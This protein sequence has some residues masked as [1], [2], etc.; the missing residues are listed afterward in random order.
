[1]MPSTRQ[2]GVLEA[3]TATA[4]GVSR[5]LRRV[6]ITA[7][8]AAVLPAASSA[9]T[10]APD[11][12]PRQVAVRASAQGVPALAPLGAP[13]FRE[14]V[15]D[16]G[17]P[18]LEVAARTGGSVN[19]LSASHPAPG[20]G[21]MYLQPLVVQGSTVR[22]RGRFSL[23]PGL[24]LAGL[25]A[26]RRD[27]T[28]VLAGLVPGAAGI[29]VA[30]SRSN[31]S[32]SGEPKRGSFVVPAGG[33][34][35]LEAEV[36]D[37][38]T[39]RAWRVFAWN[40]GEPRPEVPVAEASE[41]LDGGSAL[42]EAGVWASGSGLR[43]FGELV[44][45][46]GAQPSAAAGAA[47]ASP[48]SV[49]VTPSGAVELEVA[50]TGE[51]V[52]IE[53]D[54]F[55][56][57]ATRGERATASAAF[58]GGRAMGTC[59]GF[60]FRY[61]GQASSYPGS[62][63]FLRLSPIDN[64]CDGLFDEDPSGGGD[65]DG[66]GRTDED[67][68]ESKLDWLSNDSRFGVW[69]T[70]PV[71]ASLGY[72]ILYFPFRV[73]CVFAYASQGNWLLGTVR[74]LP[75]GGGT[76]L[77]GH[78]LA[79]VA[80]DL[81][82][83]ASTPL[84][85]TIL[86]SGAPLA[87]GALFT[88][89]VVLTALTEGGSG[90][91]TV[92]ATVDGQPFALGTSY[93]VEGTH[94]ITVAA[95]DQGG[96][97]ATA[98]RQLG[99]DLSAPVF[100]DIT[101]PDGALTAAAGVALAGRVSADTAQ[102]TVGGTPA[103]LGAA[104][105][106]T[107]P[108]TSQTVPLVEGVTTVALRA[109][110]GVGLVTELDW[111]VERDGTA[112]LVTIGS[113]SSGTIVGAAST[114][115]TGT[116]SDLHLSGVSVNG[117]AATLTGGTWSATVPLLP[118]SNQITA[119]ASDQVGNT[120]SATVTV[121]RDNTSPQITIYESGTPVSGP[122][123]LGR[124][125]VFTAQVTDDTTVQVS[126]SV[127]GATHALGT[128]YGAEGSHQL[129]VSAT[130]EG[131]NT[132]T[133][134]AAF[135]I[136]L[137]APVIEVQSP[138]A[139]SVVAA[140]A[141]TVSGR[142][143]ADTVSVQV[144]G[145]S[146]V[147]DA[148]AGEWRSFSAG[149]VAL[150]SEGTNL[151]AVQAAD[152]VG[153][154]A[155][156]E[157]PLVRDTA[158]PQ[159]T[160]TSP[161]E[162]LVTRFEAQV[163]AGQASD[164]HLQGVTLGGQPLALGAD[165]SFTTTVT[166]AEGPMSLAFVAT[167]T[168]GHATTVT[169]H[170]TLDTIP[171]AITV[172]AD[173]QPLAEGLL[174]NHA[175]APVI[176][177]QDATAVQPTILLNGVPFVS[178]TAVASEGLFL[179]SIQAVDA[180]GNQSSLDRHFRI[181]TS[182]PMLSGIQPADGTVTNQAGQTLTGQCDDAVTVTVNGA[183]AQVVSGSFT[184]AGLMLAEGENT[185]ALTATDAAGNSQTASHR[186]VLDTQPPVLT[187]SEPA[188]GA[189][190]RPSTVHVVG[191]ATDPH[192]EAVALNG[193]PAALSGGAFQAD[194]PLPNEGSNAIQVVARD[195]AGNQATVVR[196]VERDATPP[197]LVVSTPGPG[198]VL[199]SSTVQVSG[200]ATDPHL[201]GVTVNQT[202]V[203]LAGNAFSTDLSLPEGPHTI[204]VEATDTLGLSSRVERSIRVDLTAPTVLI[205]EP[206]AGAFLTSTTVPVRGQAQ[207]AEGIARVTVN[208]REAT[209]QG[210]GAFELADLALPEGESTVTCRAFDTAGNSGVVSR[211]VTVDVQPPAVTSIVPSDGATGVPTSVRPRITFSEPI[212]P[213]SLAGQITLTA[214]GVP[215]Q[216]QVALDAAAT[217]ATVTPV[218]GLQSGVEHHLTVQTGITD[219][220]G[221]VLAAAAQ[222]HFTTTDVTPPPAPQVDPLPSPACVTAAQVSGHAEPG[223]RIEVTGTV[224]PAQI[225]AG[226]DGAFA[227]SVTPTV[228]AGAVSLTVTAV[229]AAGNRSAAVPLLFD[230]DCQ[231]PQVVDATWT[232]PADPGQTVITVRFSEPPAPATLVAG[233]TVQVAGSSGALGFASALAG[234]VLELT[235]AQRPADSELPVTLDL[236]QQVT[237]LAGNALATPFRRLFTD[238]QS[239]TLVAG[240]VF[241]DATSLP[242]AGV[243]V[244][245]VEDGGPVADPHPYV[246]TDGRG[247]FQLPVAGSPVT[248][249]AER[250]GFAPGWRRVVPQP[251][252]S[253]L[254]FD[255]RLTP[256]GEIHH[257]S[258]SAELSTPGFTL[259][260]PAAAVPSEGLDLKLTP[261][262][263]QGLPNLLPP[264]WS[265]DRAVCV[266]ASVSL[267]PPAALT[268]TGSLPPDGVLATF[269]AVTQAWTA[270][271]MSAV[272]NVTASGVWAVVVPDPPPGGPGQA[273]AGFPLPAATQADP[274]E[275]TGQ[276][277][278]DPPTI[279]PTQIATGSLDVTPTYPFASGL[280]VEASLDEA[281]TLV[282]GRT[283][284]QPPAATDLVV[285]RHD[286]SYR[287]VF[288]LGASD[289]ARRLSLSQGVREVR[290]RALPAG[291]R[292]ENL[293]GPAGGTV[294]YPQGVGLV[295]AAGALSGMTS[296]D[297]ADRP[298]DLLPIPLPAG[299]A[300][301]RVV[302]L[303]LGA[304]LL[305]PAE[306]SFPL[307]PEP[308]VQHLVLVPLAIEDVT[309]WRLVGVAVRDG[310]RLECAPTPAP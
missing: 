206:A 211:T 180:A 297:L 39:S 57:F 121:I 55:D 159:L 257:L 116:A 276:L 294:A 238:G 175:I 200:T 293:V 301:E 166:L 51:T 145:Q 69:G 109:V 25:A 91:A 243:R 20:S 227:V 102:V 281:L 127:D 158:G 83:L 268:L 205:D 307:G 92:T 48:P 192:L 219:R 263:E 85:V 61:S 225:T 12:A 28:W 65:Q 62:Q 220:A 234:N 265:V 141:E 261:L 52:R 240:E 75:T 262:S 223:A 213:A 282:D 187:L 79:T 226:A 271:A 174:V 38:G 33:W 128:P 195:R 173:G 106:S 37:A 252:F 165:G 256:L 305:V 133:E 163:A 50:R 146:A 255:L 229:D 153:N 53:P 259:T 73:Y 18:V 31:G 100:S 164:P 34:F 207:D 235:L 149:G 176:E 132:A 125:A 13:V 47:A 64:D 89:P 96:Q 78:G 157:H 60:K 215:I 162:G 212:A 150:P 190:I 222:A 208:G 298:A 70:G 59:D 148:P 306:L 29:D 308:D 304:A 253:T 58:G 87:D 19:P 310:D 147:L 249:R 94:T 188:E 23:D 32:W 42:A 44:V 131:G 184:F 248:V 99:I 9:A 130:D 300:S 284:V 140:E 108:F 278:L 5:L 15:S 4:S 35:W 46:V 266:D 134:T 2:L 82:F 24:G 3:R 170:V 224:Q 292:T 118:G 110:D 218:G 246:Y 101:P 80:Y 76:A 236:T 183:P 254:V 201:L 216:V 90:A 167:D 155:A 186:L 279:L 267:T 14:V 27:G 112:P 231:P 139:G 296:V 199:A 273:A 95:S 30:L 241:D 289:E 275:L 81:S 126:A 283:L 272:L 189:T 160:V 119:V 286:T 8:L 204:V 171:P 105:G 242:L 10:S 124:P 285:Y 191:T 250:D 151:V 302:S 36:V 11:G 67:G 177:F 198:S 178:G 104:Q 269:D 49:R 277:A 138:V 56:R 136:D 26:T 290:V 209:V 88:R 168:L 97:Q 152:G 123:S 1:M 17:A 217:A 117:V 303:E 72:V 309:V 274:G 135:S 114:P 40:D 196:T 258:G 264:G 237:D 63:A 245:L 43:R 156:I 66:D 251:G 41:G 7:A 22:M 291:A 247:R 21:A 86:E 299:L 115:V 113:P 93:A 193:V 194:V 169:R 230:L 161:E 280:A 260:V 214:G 203:Q 142:V 232:R 16:D 233:S 74:V 98:T 239:L 54:A 295:V 144:G 287:A 137:T 103:S 68:P 181:D 111:H 270:V 129:T 71:D 120:S 154:T 107:R 84:S 143:S 202:P 179:L 221:R 45:E 185:L 210:T 6:V 244:T 122:L 77:R 172:R 197:D 228:P 288:R 182:K